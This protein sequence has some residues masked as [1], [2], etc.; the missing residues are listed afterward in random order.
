MELLGELPFVL[1]SCA[2]L[3]PA[4]AALIR[5]HAAATAAGMPAFVT[6]T[7]AATGLRLTTLSELRQYCYVVAG[8]VGEMLTELFLL[9]QPGLRSVGPFLRQRARA[10]GEALQLVNILKDQGNDAQE[11]R[12]YLP[13]AVPRAEIFALARGDLDRAHEYTRA[14]GDA[15]AP[16]GVV[17]FNLLITRL[18]WRT[19]EVV[20]ERGPG[21]KLSR[22]EVL[23]T[24]AEAASSLDHGLPAAGLE[25]EALAP[26][27]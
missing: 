11:G 12:I 3:R 6:L 22:S 10:F 8:V 13:A 2:E 26:S 17:A 5:V 21:A 16:R 15:G 27:A 20:E 1:A 18:A 24:V 4:A 9:D 19:L 23:A 25:G 14:L 7:D